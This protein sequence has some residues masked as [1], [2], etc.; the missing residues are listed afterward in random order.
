[1]KNLKEHRESIIITIVFHIAVLL[2]LFNFGFFTPL[3][4]PEE[5]GVLV[6]FGNSDLGM[7]MNEPTPK[8]PSSANFQK[9]EILPQ[10]EIATPQKKTQPSIKVSKESNEKILTQDY[11]K[12]AAIDET[13][14]KLNDQKQK[15]RLEKQLAD[16]KKRDSLELIN[17]ERIAEQK[18]IAE[19][20][21]QDSIKTAK[22]LAQ[23]NQINSRVKNVFGGTSS[24][25]GSGIDGKGTDVNSTGEGIT[26]N[27]GNQGSPDGS[28]GVKNYGPGGGTGSGKTVSFNLSGRTAIDLPKPSYPGNV[29]GTI[30]VE[31][32]VDKYGNVTKAIA[33]VKGSNSLDAGLMNAAQKAAMATKFNQNLEAPAFQTGTITYIFKLK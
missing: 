15:D 30:V 32:N 7:G 26:Y 16:K 11:E 27:P 13:K 22:E 2:I 3:P 5:R 31:V 10:H 14:K 25:Q 18:R 33:G 28:A 9:Q 29:E 8:E 6:D 19:I 4:L 20:K 24:G 23:I 1:V 12:T 21:R 17:E